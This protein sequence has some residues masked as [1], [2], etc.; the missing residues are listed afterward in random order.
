MEALGIL[1]PHSGRVWSRSGRKA[2]GL[3]A[4]QQS[5]V[6]KWNGG[7]WFIG[8]SKEGRV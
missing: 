7:Y 8:S 4:V 1:A 5:V 6:A 3:L 2:L